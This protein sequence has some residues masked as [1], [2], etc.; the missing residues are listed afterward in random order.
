VTMRSG[1]PLSRI[2]APARFEGRVGDCQ[3]SSPPNFGSYLSL[4]IPVAT[5]IQ[6][7]ALL[8][9]PY[10]TTPSRLTFS[11]DIRPKAGENINERK[12]VGVLMIPGLRLI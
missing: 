1:V 9:R 11:T 3:V 4:Q 5:R 7:T 2:G 12:E 10:L 6:D 8:L